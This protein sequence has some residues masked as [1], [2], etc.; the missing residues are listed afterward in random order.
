MDKT[1]HSTQSL[2]EI[3]DNRKQKGIITVYSTD[4]KQLASQSS[5]VRRLTPAD[6]RSIVDSLDPRVYRDQR[7]RP[8]YCKAVLRLGYAKITFLQSMALD[9]SVRNP[10][11]MFSW[12][13]KQELEGVA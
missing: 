5:G 12:L 4:S 2:K 10:E 8:F 9:P 13:L 11:R 7:F 6:A 3:I 1:A